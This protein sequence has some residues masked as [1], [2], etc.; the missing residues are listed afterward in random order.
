MNKLNKLS[1]HRPR[2]KFPTKKE[3][4]YY[5]AGVIDGDGSIDKIF[6]KITIAFNIKDIDFAKSLRTKIGYGKVSVRARNSATYVVTHPKGLEI[7]SK[8]IYGKLQ[9][10]HKINSLENLMNRLNIEKNKNLNI[11]LD[12]LLLKTAYLAGLIDTDGSLGMNILDRIR[13]GKIQT[14]VRLW[15]RIELKEDKILRLIHNVIGG[16]LYV[17]FHSKSKSFSTIYDTVSFERMFIILNYLDKY[18]LQSKQYQRYIFI[19]KAYLIIQNSHH[20]TEEGII[21]LRKLKKLLN[22]L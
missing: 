9:I 17:R 7:I 2:V 19:R 6:N 12:V 20:L 8:E 14:E 13:N 5:L 3:F 18:S 4:A 1:I 15:L 22:N 11:K 16:N 10:E 21:K